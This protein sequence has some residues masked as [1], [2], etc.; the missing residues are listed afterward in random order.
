MEKSLFVINAVFMITVLIHKDML[1]EM[2]NYQI[3]TVGIY[4]NGKKLLA[5][6]K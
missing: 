5:Y 3:H 1:I 6:Y 4:S 2:E